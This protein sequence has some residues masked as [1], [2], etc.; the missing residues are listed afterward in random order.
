MYYFI[1]GLVGSHIAMTVL[2]VVLG[3]AEG[4]NGIVGNVFGKIYSFYN[5]I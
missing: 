3:E 2:E 4:G 5:F 1:V